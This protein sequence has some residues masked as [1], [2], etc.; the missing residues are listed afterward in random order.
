[1]NFSDFNFSEFDQ[2]TRLEPNS[3]GFFALLSRV[4]L[5][6]QRSATAL[7]RTRLCGPPGILQPNDVI[8]RRGTQR[9]AAISAAPAAIP[10]GNDTPDDA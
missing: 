3:I 1:M 9:A 7:T 4:N 10:A 2:Q 5:V 6:H 8:E